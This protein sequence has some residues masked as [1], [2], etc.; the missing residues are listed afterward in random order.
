MSLSLFSILGVVPEATSA[1]KPEMAPQAIVMKTKGNNGPGMMGPP[2]SMYCE[3]AGASSFGLTM[4]TPSTRNAIVPI[5][6]N[7]LR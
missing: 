4:M 7:V 3:N 6:M 2:P 5:F 1:W